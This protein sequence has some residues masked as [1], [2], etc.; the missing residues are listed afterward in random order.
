VALPQ[1]KSP[2]GDLRGERARRNPIVSWDFGFLAFS[3][4]GRL[5]RQSENDDLSYVI[6]NRSLR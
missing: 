1:I 6:A 4:T 2:A 3:L 5:S